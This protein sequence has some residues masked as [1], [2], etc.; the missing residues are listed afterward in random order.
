MKG[1]WQRNTVA[2]ILIGMGAFF[3]V[4]LLTPF[5]AATSPDSLIYIEMASNVSRAD[6]L[7]VKDN[8]FTHLG[9]EVFI[10][11]KQWPPLYPLSLALLAGSE[12]D[13]MS[14]ARSS[15]VFLFVAGFFVY[16]ILVPYIDWF[17]AL[18][19][20]LLLF[21]SVPTLTIYTYAWS[22]TLFVPLLV[23]AAWSVIRYLELN[24]AGN[25]S[26]K[27]AYLVSLLGAVLGLAYT[28]YVGVVFSLLLV[29][30]FLLSRKKRQEFLA[31]LVAWAA[32]GLGLGW[33]FYDNYSATGSITGAYRMP[34]G[35][36][37]FENL[38]DFNAVL[39]VVIPVA[40]ESVAILL[41]CALLVGYAVLK[42]GGVKKSGVVA[43][44]ASH[45]ATVL[46][47][48]T[49]LYFLAIAGL[50][51]YSSFDEIDVRLLSPVFPCI[52]MLLFIFPVLSG[53]R[54][55]MG[56]WVLTFSIFLVFAFVGKG[57]VRLLETMDNWVRY[58]NPKLLLKG[59]VL[60]SNYTYKPE[61]NT[62]R[63]LFSQQRVNADSLL[64]VDGPRIMEFVTGIKSAQIP[65]VIDLEV[66]DRLNSLPA[67]SFLMMSEASRLEMFLKLAETYN[68]Q[69]EYFLCDKALVVITPIRIGGTVPVKIPRKV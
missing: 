41:L 11:Q 52:W 24:G 36:G 18:V 43:G 44:S 56:F 10:E 26:I 65:D 55:Q 61:E 29:V 69:C 13:V 2:A 20:A 1:N 19:A 28:R 17:L 49:L 37:F 31:F 57:Y 5:G 30:P 60:Y 14:V 8:S 39:R 47:F 50:R 42:K 34:S 67:R 6:G 23:I 3:I 7:V 54:R 38:F 12:V 22:E 64:V 46:V 68:F 63:V 15:A 62:A 35:K 21:M 51:S 27:Y 33:M 9:S 45:A 16:L 59:D 25:N 58:N 4:A 53:K 48:V 66:I 40:F 32:Y